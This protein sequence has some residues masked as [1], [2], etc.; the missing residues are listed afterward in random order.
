MRIGIHH[1]DFVSILH[2]N[3][4]TLGINSHMNFWNHSFSLSNICNQ[5]LFFQSDHKLLHLEEKSL[6]F[7]GGLKDF[8]LLLR[9]LIS[10][11]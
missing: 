1:D 5:L 7:Y 2:L 4:C 8:I 6:E 11:L 10:F 3:S 9:K